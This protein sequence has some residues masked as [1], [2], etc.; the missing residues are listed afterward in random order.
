MESFPGLYVLQASVFITGYEWKVLVKWPPTYLLY[1]VE[2]KACVRALR[3]MYQLLPRI[4]PW[5]HTHCLFRPFQCI[6]G[7][8]LQSLWSQLE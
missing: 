1:S 5:R 6:L 2:Q 4:E 7:F 8:M 3:G